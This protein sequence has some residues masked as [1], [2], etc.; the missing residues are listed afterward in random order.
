MSYNRLLTRSDLEIFKEHI[1]ENNYRNKFP[2][3]VLW[4]K[5]DAVL[6]WISVIENFK[7]LNI[8]NANVVDLGCGSSCP[9]KIIRSMNHSV[10][11]IE[12]VGEYVGDFYSDSDIKI[13]IGNSFDLV[14]D[15]K[16]NE[17]DIFYDCCSVTHFNTRSTTECK[18][19]GWEIMSS[20]VYKSLKKGGK[21]IIASDVR[22]TESEGEFIT[23]TD[24]INLVERSGLVLD[25]KF[26]SESIEN[27]DNYTFDY[28]GKMGVVSLTF[29]K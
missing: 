18:N 16:E 1:E 9:P 5:D 12:M 17:V 14:K 3:P 26:N 28:G 29:I 15:I 25:S 2:H 21:F 11:G 6:K 27:P 7:N 24:I 13:L 4:D 22:L 8:D 19:L 20:L 10:T 23:P